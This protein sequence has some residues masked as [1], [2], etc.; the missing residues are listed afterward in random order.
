MFQIVAEAHG[1]TALE[2]VSYGRGFKAGANH[3]LAHQWISVGDKLPETSDLVFIAL[4]DINTE[5]Y[6]YYVGY[7]LKDNKKWFLAD[8]GYVDTI[9]YWMPI[10]KIKEE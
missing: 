7:Y 2:E 6:Q 8:Y 1:R 10:P 9:S 3:A 5:S 4:F